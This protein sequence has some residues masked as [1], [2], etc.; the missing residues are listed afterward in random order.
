MTL[1]VSLDLASAEANKIFSL[2]KFSKF[3]P[4][5]K[6]IGLLRQYD[7]PNVVEILNFSETQLAQILMLN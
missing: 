3:Y 5:Q 1:N 6:V 2:E 7:I 4:N